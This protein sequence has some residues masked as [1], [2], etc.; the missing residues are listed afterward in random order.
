VRLDVAILGGGIAGLWLLA[1]LRAQGYAAM[2]FE[3]EALGAGQTLASQGIIHGGLKYAIDLKLGQDADALADMPT[4]WRACLEGKGDVDLAGVQVNALHHLFWAR[5]SIA[6]RITGFFGSKLL[7]GRV[8]A[9]PEADWPPA[10]RDPAHVG[11][12]YRLDEI[13]LDVPSLLAHFATRLAP[14]IKQCGADFRIERMGDG[15]AALLLRDPMGEERRIEAG[16]YVFAA[17]AG[18]EQALAMLG[19]PAGRAQRRPLRMLLIEGV[20]SPLYEI[21]RA[22]CRERVS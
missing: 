12:V 4:R 3:A 14:W 10:L 19:Q 1:R 2:L 9:L 8:D 16:R 6:S 20:P 7:R 5:R 21:G 11:A 18:N 13:V 22:S 15:I 17:G